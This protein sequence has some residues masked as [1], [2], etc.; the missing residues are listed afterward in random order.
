MIARVKLWWAL[1][2]RRKLRQIE[3]ER[4]R[5]GKLAARRKA[6]ANDPMRGAA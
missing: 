2:N 4:I 5:Q 1:R 3:G 6:W